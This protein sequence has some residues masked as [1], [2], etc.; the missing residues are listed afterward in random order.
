LASCW[1]RVGKNLGLGILRVT[2]S[3]YEG[4]F[5]VPK[6]ERSERSVPLA[7]MAVEIL[8][9]RMR[10]GADPKA[11]VFRTMAGGP[12]DRHNLTNR[13]LKPICKKLG[14][15]VSGGTGCA[16]PTRR[17]WTRSEHLWVRCRHFRATPRRRSPAKSTCTR[18]RRMLGRRWR[19]SRHCL[20]DPNSD[21]LGKRKSA[22]SMT[23]LK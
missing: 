21:C 13:Q 19:K 1:H 15:L 22:N 4:H 8:A 3:V 5:D 14:L 7:A 18:S 9:A 12:L 11:L 17:S 23:G 10:A 20:I 2:E 16:M 6:T